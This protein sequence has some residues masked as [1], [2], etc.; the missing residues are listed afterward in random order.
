MMVVTDTIDLGNCEATACET[1]ARV[2]IHGD[3]ICIVQACD[4]SAI[5]MSGQREALL[6]A[7]RLIEAVQG[8]IRQAVHD[9]LKES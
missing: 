6:V 4:G 8:Q 7:R 5:Q 2:E 1:D 9:E 3:M